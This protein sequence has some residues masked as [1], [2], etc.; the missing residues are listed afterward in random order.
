MNDASREPSDEPTLTGEHQSPQQK[1]AIFNSYFKL[2]E[3]IT[4]AQP[5]A[6]KMQRGRMPG[7]SEEVMVVDYISRNV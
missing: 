4:W 6:M 1:Q 3:W 5:L 2:A 7:V